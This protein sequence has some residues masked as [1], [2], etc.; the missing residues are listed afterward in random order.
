MLTV[1]IT[2]GV[3]S[4]KTIVCNI[5]RELGVAVFDADAE[6]KKLYD[7]PEVM[8]GVKKVFGGNY[9]NTKGVLDKKKFAG[10]VFNDESD[11]TSIYKSSSYIFDG[12]DPTVV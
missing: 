11:D 2:G 12:V 6:A 10:H 9:F 1:G 7:V 4:G 8:A 3:G 5:F